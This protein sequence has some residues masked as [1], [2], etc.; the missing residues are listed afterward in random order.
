MFSDTR[1]LK[2]VV[3]T[4]LSAVNQTGAI[5]GGRLDAA[6]LARLVANF[7]IPYLVSSIGFLSAHRTPSR[8][9]R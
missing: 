9:P 6:T 2:E 7:A 3:G 4:L 5:L 1:M 8:R